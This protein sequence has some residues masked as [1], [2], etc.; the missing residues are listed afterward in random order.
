MHDS[1]SDKLADQVMD[2]YAEFQ[3]QLY[4][5]GPFPM[6]DFQTF[7]EVAVRYIESVKNRPTIHRNVASAINNLRAIL[8]LKSARAPGPAIGYADRLECLLFCENDPYFEG[9]EPPGL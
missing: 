6:H 2:A 9:H 4:G 1:D 7:F 3:S 8:E 5:K